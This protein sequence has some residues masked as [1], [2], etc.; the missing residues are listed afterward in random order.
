MASCFQHGRCFVV[1]FTVSLIDPEKL[2]KRM[3]KGRAR[4][5]A[6]ITAVSLGLSLN[7]W[8]SGS[9]ELTGCCV[10]RG[11]LVAV[12]LVSVVA[13]TKRQPLRCH[14]VTL[15]FLGSNQTISSMS[16]RL[17]AL[18]WRRASELSPGLF[19]VLFRAFLWQ[20]K[21][22]TKKKLHNSYQIAN[23]WIRC[24]GRRSSIL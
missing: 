24:F 13:S 6:P 12:T 18:L 1:I 23:S 17:K 15:S 5:H 2:K 4:L 11:H 22:R 14:L 19:F 9:A 16:E 8:L 7:R 10:G 3:S 21:K 20:T